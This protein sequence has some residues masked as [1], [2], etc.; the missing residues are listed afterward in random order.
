MTRMSDMRVP[1]RAILLVVTALSL[2]FPVASRAGQTTTPT[3]VL[4]WREI[5]RRETHDASGNSR[6]TVELELVVEG[7]T[8]SRVRLGRRHAYG[9][10]PMPPDPDAVAS[11]ESYIDAQGEYATVKRVG[12][13]RLRVEAFGQDESFPD[14][15]P[16]MTNVRAAIVRIPPDASVTVDESVE[17]PDAG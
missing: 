4:R 11:V 10:T 5:Q 2:G 14:Y 9:F 6:W 1:A 16:P 12:A 7:G 8:P 15:V 3:V 13:G 17:D